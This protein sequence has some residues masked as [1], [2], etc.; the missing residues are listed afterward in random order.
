MKILSLN[1]PRDCC[2]FQWFYSKKMNS[3]ITLQLSVINA[4]KLEICSKEAPIPVLGQ[5]RLGS[6]A[7]SQHVHGRVTRKHRRC[8]SRGNIC[9][10]VPEDTGM[11]L[12]F[13]WRVRHLPIP[14]SLPPTPSFVP[15]FINSTIQRY[16]K[17]WEISG[18]QSPRLKQ[19][20]LFLTGIAKGLTLSRVVLKPEPSY[21]L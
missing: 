7:K 3:G 15:P 6:S 19:R 18:K 9:L 4:L 13:S 1:W 21:H 5:K 8:P 14:P 16:T 10:A 11:S 20:P 2:S 17:R 12:F